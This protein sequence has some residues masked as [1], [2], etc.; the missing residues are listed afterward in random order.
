M[1]NNQMFNNEKLDN[2]KLLFLDKEYLPRVFRSINY[3]NLLFVP[4]GK[5]FLMQ[6]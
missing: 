4:V 1:L 5:A 6:M 3:V 2:E